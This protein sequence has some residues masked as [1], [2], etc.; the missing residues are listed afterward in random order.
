MSV[1]TEMLLTYMTI[2]T[3]KSQV[4]NMENQFLKQ[5]KTSYIVFIITRNQP[6]QFKIKTIYCRQE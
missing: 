5:M 4:K 6:D 3:Q 1:K 2:I